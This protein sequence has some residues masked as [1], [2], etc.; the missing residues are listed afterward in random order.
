MKILQL[1]DTLNPG[2]AERMAVNYANSLSELG[3]D[4]YLIV[5]RQ[6]GAFKTL[7]NKKVDYY[8]LRKKRTIDWNAFLR[9]DEYIK[10]NRIE[11]IHAHGTSWF[12][13]VVYKLL[14]NNVKLIWHDHY[15]ESEFLNKRDLFPLKYFSGKFDG[16]ISVN[17]RLRDWAK[18]K[19][20]CKN[21]IFLNNYIKENN[22]KNLSY[23]QLKGSS[24]LKI[25]C[26]ANLRQQKDHYSLLEAFGLVVQTHNVSL[27][28]FGKEYGDQY[29]FELIKKFNSTAFIY[30][31]GEKENISHWLAQGDIGVLSSLSEGLPLALLEYGDAGLAVV[32]TDVGECRQVIGNHGILVSPKKPKELA[33]ALRLYLDDDK[34]RIM[35][36]NSLNIRIN[37]FHSEKSIIPCYFKFLEQLC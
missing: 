26:V 4:S 31:Y 17:K 6:E 15:G 28:L 36:S 11:I 7:L 25:I 13:A 10:R 5:T 27:H 29:S 2:G 35:D 12:I 18:G 14:R 22:N 34:K 1:I 19:L 9:F 16:V 20:Y 30:Y 32:C 37:Q 23:T 8:Y 21:V 33:H 24:E 3:H